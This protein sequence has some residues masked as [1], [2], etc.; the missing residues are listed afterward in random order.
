MKK[1]LFTLLSVVISVMVLAQ[2]PQSFN[3]QAVVRDNSGNPI[4]SQNVSLR[5]SILQTSETGTP[6]YTETHN[7]TT[8][9]FGLVTLKIGEG[10]STDDFTAIDWAADKYFVK[11]EVDPAG[12]TDYSTLRHF[13]V[14]I[15]SLCIKCKNCG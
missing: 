2:A 6:V 9:A 7:A 13:T 15:C 11:V 14:I 1:I 3:Y 12:G 4:A 10:T 8:N 5:I